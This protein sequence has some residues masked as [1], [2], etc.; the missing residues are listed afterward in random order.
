MGVLAR[1]R[2]DHCRPTYDEYLTNK[3]RGQYR[4][5]DNFTY[6]PIPEPASLVVGSLLA[7][8][9]AGVVAARKR[10][11]KASGAGWSNENR[12]DSLSMIEGRG[13]HQ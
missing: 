1:R 11:S 3:R 9:S 10:Q 8:A 5:L 6:S 2:S 12:D 7:G 4:G 13:H